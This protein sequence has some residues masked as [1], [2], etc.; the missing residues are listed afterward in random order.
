[1]I[2]FLKENHF[3]LSHF[4]VLFYFTFFKDYLTFEREGACMHVH[5]REQCEA[6]F[7]LSAAP[8]SVRTHWGLFLLP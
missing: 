8:N 2:D 5:G 4:P 3:S 1:M 6:D 7:T